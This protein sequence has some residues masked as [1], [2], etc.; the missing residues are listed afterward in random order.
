MALGQLWSWPAARM[1]SAVREHEILRVVATV[2]G[3]DTAKSTELARREVLVCGPAKSGGRFPPELGPFRNLVISPAGE[4]ASLSASKI[5]NSTFGRSARMIRT[6]WCQAEPGRQKSSWDQRATDHPNSARACSSVHPKTLLRSNPIHRGLFSKSRKHA[7]S[8][9][10]YDL[11]PEPWL[12]DSDEEAERL[13]QMLVDQN[14]MLP[15]FVLTTPLDLDDPR[16]PLLDAR[17][18]ARATLGLSHVA[19]VPAAF[20]WTLTDRFG[21]RRSV[22]GGAARAYLPSFAE[23][24]NPYGHRLMFAEELATS[25]GAAECSRWMRSLAAT[26]SVRRTRLGKEVLAFA[27]IRNATFQLK[28]QRLEQEGASDSQKLEAAHA[29]ITALEADLTRASETESFLLDEHKQAEE[30]AQ[31][32][33][34]QLI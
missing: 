19:I 10:P 1:P 18:L 34:G 12:I 28:Q 2:Q 13:I 20:T 25:E 4:T 3:K 7:D 22:F 17:T 32:A 29:Q 11:N 24:S 27:T 15:V 26:E 14:R 23:D 9:G 30:R 6:R 8:R 31:T 33:E 16:R 21:K 5:T